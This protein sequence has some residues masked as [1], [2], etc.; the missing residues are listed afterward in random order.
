MRTCRFDF[1]PLVKTFR[2]GPLGPGDDSGSETLT[3]E[4]AEARVLRPPVD[5]RRV[6]AVADNFSLVQ[7]RDDFEPLVFLKDHVSV[8]GHNENVA[9]D[10]AQLETWGE[11][12]LAVVLR[13]TPRSPS[14]KHAAAS[15]LGYT[16][17]NDFTSRDDSGRDH[18]LARYKCGVDRLALGPWLDTEFTPG[19]QLIAGWQDGTV[20]RA[21][22]VSEMRMEPLEIIS[23][24]SKWMVLG[25]NDVVLTGAPSRV[26]ER[27]FLT[28]GCRYSCSIEGL[29]VLSNG[30]GR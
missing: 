13:D 5:C 4:E 24:L 17:A 20:I 21:G 6:I 30:Y 29:G 7:E 2:I 18:H 15:V 8:R 14:A 28:V 27:A 1:G 19:D 9:V 12:E 23:W 26:G 11:P 25:A 10:G 3:V 22:R 16:I